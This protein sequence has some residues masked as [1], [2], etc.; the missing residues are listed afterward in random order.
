[1]DLILYG[2]SGHEQYRT[3][4]RENCGSPKLMHFDC[5]LTGGA[6]TDRLNGTII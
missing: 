2:I 6:T 4:G 5:F 1:M 3:R